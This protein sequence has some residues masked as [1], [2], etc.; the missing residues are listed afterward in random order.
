MG[1]LENS[2]VMYAHLKYSEGYLCILKKAKT[3]LFL[4]FCV[5]WCIKIGCL[6]KRGNG[7]GNTKIAHNVLQIV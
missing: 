6:K 4:H 5:I 7:N 3:G 1:L 2:K